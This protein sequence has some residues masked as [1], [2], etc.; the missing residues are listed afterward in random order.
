MKLT[1]EMLEEFGAYK[2]GLEVS[3]PGLVLTAELEQ[4]NLRVSALVGEYTCEL[5]T[6]YRVLLQSWSPTN[7]MCRMADE[8]AGMTLAYATSKVEIAG[9][10]H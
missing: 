8:V 1:L 5:Q 10:I 4:T 2:Q 7:V 9:T 3:H 6:P